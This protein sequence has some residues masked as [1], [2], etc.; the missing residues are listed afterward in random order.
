MG[1]K[2]LIYGFIFDGKGGGKT[3]GLADLQNWTPDQ[4]TLWLHFDYSVDATRDWISNESG[5]DEVPAEALLT[6]ET[7]PRTS[8]IDSGALIA[9]RGVNLNPGSDPEDMVSVRLWVEEHRVISTRRRPLLSCTEIAK[10]L[11]NNRGPRTTGDFIA[12]LADALITNMETTIEG[13]E[14]RLAELEENILESESHELRTNLSMIR[15]EAIML[16][17][18]LAPQREALIKLYTEQ[19]PWLSQGDRVRIREVTD[20]LIRYLE[21][22]DTVRDRAAVTLEELINRI[23]EQMNSR[24]YVLSLVAAVFLPLGFL[25]GLLGINVGGIPGSDNNQAFMVVIALMVVVAIG[26]IIFFH[27][28]KW[29]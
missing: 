3:V 13:I 8:L 29:L 1:E 15:R 18:Y 5:L 14:D 26:E 23:S 21:D 11:R 22:L 2:G 16:R 4:G 27:R 24:M 9:L 19:F 6:E 10:S 25:T 28:K 12:R 17:R 7:R 20:C